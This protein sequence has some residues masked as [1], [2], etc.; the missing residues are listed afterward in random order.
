MVDRNLTNLE[1]VALA[2]RSEMES[3]DLYEKLID[4][5]RNPAV[6]KILKE[7]ADDEE[8]HRQGLMNLYESMLGDQEPSIPATD[9]RDKDIHL[10]PEAEFID[11]MKAARDKEYDSEA[12]YKNAAERVMDYK[13][14]M[15]FL[16]LAETERRHAEV[17][18]EQVKRLKE[19]PHWFDREDAQPFKS[20]HEGP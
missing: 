17:L 19:D 9:G 10:D 16:D 7:L 13:T 15:F 14:R 5:V 3:N 8:Q 1:A 4:R 6:V 12:F 18:Q 2:V 11:V 20:I